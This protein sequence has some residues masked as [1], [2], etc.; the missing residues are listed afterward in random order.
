V[1]GPGDLVSDL[2]PVEVAAGRTALAQV[3]LGQVVGV[4]SC[5]GGP[6]RAPA[7]P[8]PTDTAPRSP[9]NDNHPAVIGIAEPGSTVRLF[10]DVGCRGVAVGQGIA[11]GDG[12]FRIE[13]TVADNTS[14]RFHATASNREGYTSPCSSASAHYVE[15][16][17][18]PAVPT[19]LAVTPSPPAND[20]APVIIG[21]AEPG[22]IVTLH[23]DSAC[24]GPPLAQTAAGPN[25]AFRAVLSVA[26]NSTTSIHA[27]AIDA[28]GNG[29]SRTACSPRCRS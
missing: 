14:T 21:D 2:R 29:S 22:S 13:V 23:A 19:G 28:A 27:R 20:N 3:V 24:L 17:V 7:V 4:G 9:A 15:D 16:S 5:L 6:T 11:A 12:A 25:G 1:A 18:P 10:T 8:I 26:D